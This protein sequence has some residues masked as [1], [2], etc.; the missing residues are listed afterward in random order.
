MFVSLQPTAPPFDE[1]YTG[2]SS[3]VT[4]DQLKGKQFRVN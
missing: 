4:V 1:G 2:E 3:E